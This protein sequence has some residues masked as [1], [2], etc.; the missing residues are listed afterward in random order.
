MASGIAP[1]VKLPK[2]KPRLDVEEFNK[3][4]D[5]MFEMCKEK[6]Q[7]CAKLL[8]ISRQ[9]WKRWEKEP[10]DWP[11][12]NLVI[13]YVIREY[14]GAMQARKGLT[15]KHRHRIMAALQR[16]E[17]HEELGEEISRIAYNLNGC[18][19]HLTQLLA[20]GGMF[21]D[22]IRLP[23]NSGGYSERTLRKTARIL[24]LRMSQEGFG[25]NKRSFWRLPTEYDD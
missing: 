16:I 14:L 9:T 22:E 18:E 1:R 21:W 12:W 15:R 25:P 3:L 6:H 5:L 2:F 11:Y 24:N 4:T 19:R 10:P 7:T 23:A 13:R 17:N 20:T 8:G